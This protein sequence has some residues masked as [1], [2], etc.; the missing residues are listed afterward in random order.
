MA[1]TI[2]IAPFV[3]GRLRLSPEGKGVLI[4]MRCKQCGETVFP[5][6]TLCPKCTGDEVEEVTLSRRGKLYS[7]TVVYESYGNFIGLVAPYTIMF[8]LLPEG[9]CVHAPLVGCKPEEIAIG[10]DVELDLLP[11]T[12]FDGTQQA[13][14]VFRPVQ[15]KSVSTTEHSGREEK[16]EVAHGW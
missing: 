10:M 6:E 4:G 11:F 14:Y 16:G 15:A 5:T 13:A 8:V 2:Q 12:A 7:Y 9:A 3:K 1:E